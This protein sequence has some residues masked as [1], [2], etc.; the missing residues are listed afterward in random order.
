M[1][2]IIPDILAAARSLRRSPVY[3]TTAVGTLAL[4]VGALALSFAFVNAFFLRPMP[5]RADHQLVGVSMTHRVASGELLDYAVSMNDYLALRERNRSF[6]EI[7]VINQQSYA[8]LIGDAPE[9]IRGGRVSATMWSVLEATPAAGR[10]FDQAEDLPDAA[11]VVISSALQRRVFPGPPGTAVGKTLTSD[12]V[13]R[14]VIGVMPRGFRPRM[15]PGDLWLPLGA[16]AA[17]PQ[18]G[19]RQ[20]Q[21]VARRREGVSLEEART[22]VNRIARELEAERP[23]TN[24]EW[25]ASTKDLRAKIGDRAR[26]ITIALVAS[27]AFMLIL[28]CANT[29]NLAIARVVARRNDI[30][31]RLAL[32]ASASTVARHYVIEAMLI[33]MLGGVLGIGLAATV[34]PLALNVLTSDNPLLSLVVLDWRVLAIGVATSVLAGAVAS[35][36]P[37]LLSLRLAATA[38]IG[39]TVR[40][41]Y[42]NAGDKRL[43]RALMTVQVGAAT[44]LLIGSVSA[45]ASLQDLMKTDVGYDPV[46]RMVATVTLPATRYPGLVERSAFVAQVQARLA[47]AP[48]IHAVGTT[49]GQFLRDT[50]V[51]SMFLIVG[52][53]TMTE[54]TL[55]A[56]VRRVTPEFFTALDIPLLRGRTFGVVDRDSSPPVAIINRSFA[57]KYLGNRDALTTRIRR[58]ALPPMDVI[59]IVP[60]S[61]DG[62]AG[63]DPGPTVYLPIAQSAVARLSFVLMTSLDARTAGQTIR[64]ALR[65]VDPGLP[66]DR[67]APLSTMMRESLGEERFRTVVL[68]TM[69]LLALLIACVGIYGV[70]AYLVQQSAREVAI[71]IALGASQHRV[72][73]QL[74]AGTAASVGVGVLAGLTVSWSGGA[75]LSERFPELV[76]AGAT[77]YFGVAVA[78]LVIGIVAGAVPSIRASRASPSSALR[79]D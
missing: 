54:P 6:T 73:A 40:R 45:V 5:F 22:D 10:V 19:A 76:P 16:S 13:A 56:E 65:A 4:G 62:G 58:G 78:L 39:H 38:A 24:R 74:L 43:R 23:A 79:S 42:V 20:L 75:R 34:L 7:G 31:T 32:G 50:R 46:N 9:S 51:Q 61:R 69:T 60:D 27:V 21:T 52:D 15:N 55:A 53:E 63:E 70:T 28:T 25:G 66:I 72:L 77:V 36:A 3:T 2:R 48:G 57:D 59:G 12:G 71:R 8:V 33:A 14:V 26:G 41:Q 44:I 68:G 47:G 49:T 64:D 29:A 37:A 67:V 1:S 35:A 18:A 17:S 11:V 30:A